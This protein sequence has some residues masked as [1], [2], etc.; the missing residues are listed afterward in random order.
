MSRLLCNFCFVWVGYC[1]IS[2]FTL[3]C[4]TCMTIWYVLQLTAR[5]SV[6][7]KTTTIWIYFYFPSH[8]IL[9]DSSNTI[10][11]DLSGLSWDETTS[12]PWAADLVGWLAMGEESNVQCIRFQNNPHPPAWLLGEEPSMLRHCSCYFLPNR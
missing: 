1:V 5:I 6:L 2:A 9:C 4:C 8:Q 10:E 12:K 7:N 11:N 3:M